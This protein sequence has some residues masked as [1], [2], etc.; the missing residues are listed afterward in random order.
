MRPLC[1]AAEAHLKAAG[2]GSAARQL[3]RWQPIHSD[4]REARLAALDGWLSWCEGARDVALRHAIRE[5]EHLE[6]AGE[7]FEAER[8]RIYRERDRRRS[9]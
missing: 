3:Q 4:E 8:E 7:A 9:A 2:Y 1:P 5:V 6:A